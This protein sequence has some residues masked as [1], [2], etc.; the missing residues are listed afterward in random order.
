[1]DMQAGTGSGNRL[2]EGIEDYLKAVFYL[3]QEQSLVS[4]QQLAEHLDVNPASVSGMLKRLAELDLVCYERYRGVMLTEAGLQAALCIVRRHRLLER[5][6]VE[7]LDLAWDQVHEVAEVWEHT[8]STEVEEH[9]ADL[10]GHPTTDPH[11]ALIPTREGRLPQREQ[12]RLS[13]LAAGQSGVI[14]EVSDGDPALLRYLE[15]LSLRP[16]TRVDVVAVVPVNGLMRVRIAGSEQI[17]RLPV[18]EHVF[19]APRGGV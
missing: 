8:L 1:M 12:V 9:I 15:G 3:G 19:L 18:A 7:K 17:V 4:N 2:T 16:G 10:L 11:G 5:L 6:L 14:T 13:T